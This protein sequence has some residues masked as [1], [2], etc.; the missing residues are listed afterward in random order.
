MVRFDLKLLP[1]NAEDASISLA[2]SLADKTMKHL[3]GIV[4]NKKC[5]KHPSYVNRIKINA[6][7]DQ[8]PKVQVVDYCCGEFY[9]ILK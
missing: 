4:G 2:N 8:D 9:K 7:K 3:K 1:E 5:H 6:V